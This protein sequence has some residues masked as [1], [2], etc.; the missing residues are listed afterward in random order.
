MQLNFSF[1]GKSP[2]FNPLS[3]CNPTICRAEVGENLLHGILFGKSSANQVGENM[4]FRFV[5]QS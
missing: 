5:N 3:V 1:V 4:A 2:N